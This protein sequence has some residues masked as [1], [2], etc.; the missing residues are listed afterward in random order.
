MCPTLSFAGWVKKS[1]GA[2]DSQPWR[3]PLFMLRPF[4]TSMMT[5]SACHRR[6]TFT[7]GSRATNWRTGCQSSHRRLLVWPLSPQIIWTRSWLMDSRKI[8]TTGSTGGMTKKN[9]PSW[10][11]SRGAPK[12]AGIQ[13][14][15]SSEQNSNRTFN[16]STPAASLSP[17][18]IIY[19]NAGNRWLVLR[20]SVC[21]LFSRTIN[22]LMKLSRRYWTRIIWLSRGRQHILPR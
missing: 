2:L 16:A 9:R 6:A 1:E 7:R 19:F 14:L 13:R 10:L 22:S 21:H 5:W 18:L 12:R 11:S 3:N 4:S 20:A 8:S 17:P 15:A